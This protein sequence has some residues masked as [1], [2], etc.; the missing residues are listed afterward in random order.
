M[1][2]YKTTP[3]QKKMPEELEKLVKEGKLEK[4]Y[5]EKFKELNKLWKDIDHGVIKEVEPKHLARA[6]ELATD[7]INRMEKLLPKEI[8]E[9][10]LP[11]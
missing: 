9:L 6:M 3:D 4:E 7:I 2:Y 1:Y 11:V 8:K 10:D 5:V